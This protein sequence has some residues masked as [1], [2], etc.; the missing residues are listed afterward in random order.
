M[1][2]PVNLTRTSVEATALPSAP[3]QDGSVQRAAMAMAHIRHRRWHH[4]SN[5]VQSAR[6][7][8]EIKKA[9]PVQCSVV[10]MLPVQLV[11]A[12]EANP[13]IAQDGAVLN[14]AASVAAGAAADAVSAWQ[15]AQLQ[16]RQLL[17]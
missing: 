11:E 2:D 10:T 14:A 5:A 17:F 3:Q 1:E 13:V 9:Q 4:G 6:V 12:A 15:K 7:L 8:I 16:C